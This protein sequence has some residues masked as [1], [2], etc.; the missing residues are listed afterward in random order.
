MALTCGE[1]PDHSTI[2][3]FVSSMRHEILPMFRDVLLVCEE[4]GL[5]G[6]TFFC[7]GWLQASIVES[8][9][10][11]DFILTPIDERRVI[12][13]HDKVLDERCLHLG[14]AI[15]GFPFLDN[16][17]KEITFLLSQLERF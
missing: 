6:G 2:A 7:V 1:Y 15:G 14:S 13:I 16:G 4:E 12:E 9:A 17:K 3:A 11:K 8:I 10:E 5:P